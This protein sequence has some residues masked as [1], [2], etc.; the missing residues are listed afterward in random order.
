MDER[1]DVLSRG[2]LAL[3]REHFDDADLA[4]EAK[5]VLLTGGFGPNCFLSRSSRRL[6]AGTARWLPG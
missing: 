4:Y 3:L 6:P 2:L 1:A 5:P